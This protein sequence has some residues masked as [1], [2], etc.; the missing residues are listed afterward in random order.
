MLC[1]DSTSKALLMSCMESYL[2]QLPR[3]SLSFPHIEEAQY[4]NVDQLEE[5]HHATS[6]AIF[7][8]LT[9]QSSPKVL[10]L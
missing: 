6:T 10:S 1:I 8:F 9:V 7:F 5:N 3:P 4:L 2:Y